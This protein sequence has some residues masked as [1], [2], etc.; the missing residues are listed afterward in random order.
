MSNSHFIP[1]YQKSLQPLKHISPSLFSSLK[2][3]KLRALWA[4]NHVP[5]MFPCYPTARIGLIVHRVI[6]ESKGTMVNEE[7]FQKLWDKCVQEQEAQIS[8]SCIEKHLVPL[9][10]MASDFHIKKRQCF[11]LLQ[12]LT[13]QLSNPDNI[14]HFKALSYSKLIREKLLRSKDSRVIGVADEIRFDKSGVTIIDYKTGNLFG[15][16]VENR[17]LPAYIEQL[18][19][20]S[21]V[22]LMNMENGLKNYASSVWMGK[23]SMLILINLNV[24]IC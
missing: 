5:N 19:L 20:Y 1:T 6:E 13:S 21:S 4:Y 8:N 17:V 14:V 7:T 10:L 2:K 24:L 18:K 3:C 12:N 16:S 11:L 22:F 15:Q 9:S 23:L